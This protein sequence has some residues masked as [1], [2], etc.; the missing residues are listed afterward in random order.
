MSPNG[1]ILQKKYCDFTSLCKNNVVVKRKRATNGILKSLSMLLTCHAT[2]KAGRHGLVVT[3]LSVVLEGGTRIKTALQT[4]FRVFREN[5]SD[6]Q[7]SAWVAHLLQ[8]LG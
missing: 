2:R 8:C 3:R 7:F 1:L 4:S 5:H 6:M